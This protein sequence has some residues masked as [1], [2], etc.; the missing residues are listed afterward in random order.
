MD[1]EIRD[2][3]LGLGGKDIL[4]GMTLP[5]VSANV[6]ALIGPSGGGKSTLLRVIGGLLPP[7]G[8]EVLL[9]RERLPEDEKSLRQCR[10]KTGM[11]FQNWNLF[12]HLTAFENL[13]LPLTQV[14]GMPVEEAEAKSMACLERFQLAD[15]AHK[16]PHQ[17]SGGQQ[18]RVAII[19]ALVIEPRCLLLDEPTSAL[20]P[21]MAAQVLEMIEEVAAQGTPV[22][23]VTHHLAFARRVSDT[24]LFLAEGQI[25]EHG[26]TSAF[27]ERPQTEACRRFLDRVM[28]M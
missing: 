2:L 14:Q 7:D 9:N 8:G 20:D 10:R 19:R 1:L 18:Q 5:Q 21:E 23:L 3:Q 17:L 26:P 11:V 16:K 12:H 13:M 15:H 25:T 4:Q 27:F 22:M 6:F 28:R 24:T